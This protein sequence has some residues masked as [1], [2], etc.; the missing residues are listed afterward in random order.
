[1]FLEP[2]NKGLVDYEDQFDKLKHITTDN[3][4]QKD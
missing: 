4:H 2:F 1:M 3:Y